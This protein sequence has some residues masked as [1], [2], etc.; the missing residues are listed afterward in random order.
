MSAQ[1]RAERSSRAAPP[2]VNRPPRFNGLKG[3]NRRGTW[4]ESG[5]GDNGR[6][7]LPMESTRTVLG[8][9]ARLDCQPESVLRLPISPKH[10]AHRTRRHAA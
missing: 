1:G 2:W 6:K 4:L 7:T 10:T 5:V 9:G 3:Q 8:V